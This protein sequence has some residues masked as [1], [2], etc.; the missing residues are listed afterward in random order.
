MIKSWRV[1]QSLKS[2]SG[3]YFP[4]LLLMKKKGIEENESIKP[5]AK[6]LRLSQTNSTES[7]WSRLRA[8]V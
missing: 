1:V 7:L 4:N 3:L 6:N 8:G 2:V 5:T